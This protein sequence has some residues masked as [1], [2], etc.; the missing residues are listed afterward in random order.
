MAAEPAT[1]IPIAANSDTQ[2]SQPAREIVLQQAAHELVFAVVGH[3]GS[4]TSEVAKALKVLLESGSLSGGAYQTVILKARRE[5][6]EWAK[7]TDHAL[8]TT[9]NQNLQ[10]TEAFQ[11]LGDAMRLKTNDNAAVAKAL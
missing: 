8:P 5:I 7:S 11:D 9:P 4:G 10:S 6:E 1:N 3:V 2:P